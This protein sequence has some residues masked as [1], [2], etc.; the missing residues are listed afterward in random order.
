M[1]RCYG[2]DAGMT[3]MDIVRID[4]LKIGAM[5]LGTMKEMVLMVIMAVS[6][7]EFSFA[8]QEVSFKRGSHP[9][10]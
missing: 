3:K 10:C 1:P 5:E 2:V 6:S 7:Q 9:T 8:M 4:I